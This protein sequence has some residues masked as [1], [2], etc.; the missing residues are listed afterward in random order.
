MRSSFGSSLN[1]RRYKVTTISTLLCQPRLFHQGTR[2][3]LVR[4]EI[5][6][7][8]RITTE[9]HIR[10]QD[11]LRPT[12]QVFA[13]MQQPGLEE[14]DAEALLRLNRSQDLVRLCKLKLCFLCDLAVYPQEAGC[15]AIQVAV[16]VEHA[17]E[18]RLLFPCSLERIV[19][20]CAEEPT[21]VVA[22]EAQAFIQTHRMPNA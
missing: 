14:Q 18:Q 17:S 3:D 4:W 22:A 8:V 10:P 2:L 5:W 12:A 21:R 11:V 19:T 9:H 13:F 1:A 15:A 20:M 6:Q 7:R 16:Q